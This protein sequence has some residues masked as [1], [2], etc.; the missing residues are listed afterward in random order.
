MAYRKL[1][2]WFRIQKY[3]GICQIYHFGMELVLGLVPLNMVALNWGKIGKCR[4]MSEYGRILVRR[5]IF[6]EWI[7]SGIFSLPGAFSMQSVEQSGKYFCK[8]V[9]G[10]PILTERL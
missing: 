9:Q 1:S 8:Q 7:L 2:M 4:E 5:V 10:V 6:G 3:V